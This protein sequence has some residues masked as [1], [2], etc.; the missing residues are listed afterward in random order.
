MPKARGWVLSIGVT[1]AT[2]VAS[3]TKAGVPFAALLRWCCNPVE[4]RFI[5]ELYS[6][7]EEVW[8][9]WLEEAANI[10]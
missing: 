2:R 9:K 6:F 1:P 3:F 8:K 5:R 7:Q 4:A 10:L